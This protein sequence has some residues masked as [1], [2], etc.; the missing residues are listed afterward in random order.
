MITLERL[1]DVRY[2]AALF[3][4]HKNTIYEWSKDGRL[5][6]ISINGRVRFEREAIKEFIE[7]RKT[8]L[9]DPGPLLQS[10]TLPLDRFDRINLKGGSAVESKTRRSWNYGFGSVYLRKTKEGKDRW[11]IHGRDGQG[12]FREVV[13]DALTRGDAVV[14]LQR[15]VAESFNGTYAPERTA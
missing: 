4:V 10:V 2:V 8:R 14:A 15:R 3:G 9:I 13:K 12:R 11:S 6:S 1:Y 5:P 7:N